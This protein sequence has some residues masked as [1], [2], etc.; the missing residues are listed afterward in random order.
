MKKIFLLWIAVFLLPVLLA[1]TSQADLLRPPQRPATRSS[2]RRNNQAKTK[3][4]RQDYVV[5]IVMCD[6]DGN[7]PEEA[8]PVTS[9]QPAEATSAP[10]KTVKK[11]PVNKKVTSAATVKKQKQPAKPYTFEVL[12]TWDTP[13]TA[14]N[15]AWA[16]TFQLVWNDFVNELL[17]EPATF[18]SGNP[19]TTDLLNKQS[20]TEDDLS[21]SAYYK[22]W[23]PTSPDLKQEME[24]GI[25]E[26]FNETSDV[27]NRGDWTPGNGKYT[28]YAMLKKDF[29][30]V[31]AFKKLQ[32]G[33]FTGSS[34]KVNYFG[35]GEEKSADSVQV[36]FYNNANDFAVTL[37]SKEGDRIHL[38]RTDNTGTLAELYGNMQTA[39]RAYKGMHR[40]NNVDQF[41][42]PMIEFN[43][44]RAFEE[45]CNQPIRF[46]DHDPLEI[47]LALETIRF[48]MDEKGVKLKSEAIMQTRKTANRPSKQ[49]TPRYFNFTNRYVIF[50]QENGKAPYFALLVTDAAKL[51]QPG[52]FTQPLTK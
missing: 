45:I 40:L 18:L 13:S 26:K 14:T 25:K 21:P 50:A 52:A 4:P 2:A 6:D 35:L 11:T 17:H 36:L 3:T 46:P 34:A 19:P 42:A 30:Y 31:A 49:P 39:A 41:K 43:S 44:L 32:P 28:F 29:E 5:E 33:I 24:Q 15:Q 8:V 16:G 20:F 12:P 23:G 9:L 37:L 47:T 22:K 51:Q 27:L 10:A 38:Y 7:C 1:E 48:K